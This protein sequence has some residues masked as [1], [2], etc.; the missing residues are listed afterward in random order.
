MLSA[1]GS[2]LNEAMKSLSSTR[3]LDRR[4]GARNIVKVLFVEMSDEQE[5]MAA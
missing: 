4:S 2:E 5:A 3:D 1:S